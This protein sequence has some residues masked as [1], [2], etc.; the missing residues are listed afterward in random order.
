MPDYSA[1]EEYRKFISENEWIVKVTFN[2]SQSG[3]KVPSDYQPLKG[4]CAGQSALWCANVLEKKSDLKPSY[5]QSA[6]LQ[7]TYQGVGHSDGRGDDGLIEWAGLKKLEKL[8]DAAWHVVMQMRYTAGVY[9]IAAP[10]H[11]MAA[12]SSPP[13]GQFAFFNPDAGM[14]AGML[15]AIFEKILLQGRD[16]NRKWIAYRVEAVAGVPGKR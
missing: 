13:T 11:W 1:F 5:L 8:Y 16:S 2:L 12:S 15:P 7:S 3:D 14:F 10:G 4:I 9:L 6:L